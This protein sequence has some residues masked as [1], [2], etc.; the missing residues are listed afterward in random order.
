MDLFFDSERFSQLYNCTSYRV[1]DVP[2]EQRQN[3]PVGISMLAIFFIFSS[4]HAICLYAMRKFVA[5]SSAYK[6][7][8]LMGIGH[9]CSLFVTALLTGLFS[10][11]GIVFCSAPF[12]N[13]FAGSMAL[14]CWSLTTSLSVLLAFDRCVEQTLPN[15]ANSLFQGCRIWGWCLA[16]LAYAIYYGFFTIPLTFSGITA[17]WQFDPH[18]GYLED[19]SANGQNLYWNSIDAIHTIVVAVLLP[20]LYLFFVVMFS[21]KLTQ[22]TKLPMAESKHR[23]SVFLQVFILSFVLTI[24]SINYTLLNFVPVPDLMISVNMYLWVLLDVNNFVDSD[25]QRTKTTVENQYM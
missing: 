4:L 22:I 12:L 7:M 19:S 15:L 21:L 10:I 16:I 9:I 17:N 6:V 25:K 24:F 2:F 5:H 20:S 18:V 14:F 1:D 3:L 11:C 13:F 23:K 8:F